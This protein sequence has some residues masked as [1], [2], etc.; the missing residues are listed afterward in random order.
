MRREKT[1]NPVADPSMPLSAGYLRGRAFNL[2]LLA[3]AQAAEDPLEAV[4]IGTQALE[5]AHSLE[6]RRTLAYLRD[7]RNRLAAYQALPDVENFRRQVSTIT[8][9]AS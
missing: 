1:A 2:C 8:A 4:R 7:L 9:S 6:S 3:S 5:L